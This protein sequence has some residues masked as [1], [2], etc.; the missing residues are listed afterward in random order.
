VNHQTLVDGHNAMH[1][2]RLSGGPVESLR[3]RLVTRVRAA[4]PLGAVVYFDGHPSPGA[5]GGTEDRGVTVRYAGDRE[6]DEAIVEHVRDARHPRRL[7]VVT[8]DLELAR[9]VEQLG[10]SSMR[11]AQL[12]ADVQVAEAPEKPVVGGF[13][14][15][16]FGLAEEIDLSQP[17]VN[18]DGAA[19]PRRRPRIPPRRTRF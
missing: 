4:A 11:V 7:V 18:A 12:F 15:A 14:A 2:L 17:A 1:R 16:D 6:A 10:A 19:I 3:A 13:R 8:D 9:R 5:F